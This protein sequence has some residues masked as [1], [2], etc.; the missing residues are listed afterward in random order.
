MQKTHGQ[1]MYTSNY[2]TFSKNNS[3]QKF[4]FPI[5]GSSPCKIEASL[6]NNEP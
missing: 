2:H 5:E 4:G 1:K 6:L 3:S